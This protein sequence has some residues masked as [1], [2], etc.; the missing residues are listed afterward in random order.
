[1]RMTLASATLL[2]SCSAPSAELLPLT[3]KHADACKAEL[4]PR[5]R[6]LPFVA[7]IDSKIKAERALRRAEPKNGEACKS[8]DGKC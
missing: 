3:G 1:M 8:P 7:C 2:L 6:P 5:Y 4:G